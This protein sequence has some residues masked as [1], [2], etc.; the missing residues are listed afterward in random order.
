MSRAIFYDIMIFVE[1][2]FAKPFK[3]IY[4]R[5][6]VVTMM[7]WDWTVVTVVIILFLI[8]NSQN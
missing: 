1:K 5:L 2:R 6:E 4:H 3:T 7:S 8:F